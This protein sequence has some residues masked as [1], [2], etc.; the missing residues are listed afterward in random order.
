MLVEGKI[1][2]L[3]LEKGWSQEEVANKLNLSVNGYG[4]IERGET[5]ICL[6]RLEQIASIYDMNVREFFG[7]IAS[8]Q[9]GQSVLNS[10]GNNNSGTQNN[11]T[12]CAYNLNAEDCKEK[13]AE[14]DSKLNTQLLINEF[15]LK[16]NVMLQEHNKTLQEL[17][18][19]MKKM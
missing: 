5:D 8:R 14:R 1:R 9:S 4:C 16:E 19:Q 10:M 2:S 15:Q 11:Q 7:D 12:Y 18:N 13:C 17:N 3:R 6:S